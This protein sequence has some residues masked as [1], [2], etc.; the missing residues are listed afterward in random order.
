M[1]KVT[2]S[3]CVLIGVL[4]VCVFLLSS[5]I[6]FVE[7]VVIKDDVVFR[8]GDAL[9]EVSDNV[10]MHNKIIMSNDSFRLGNTYF[11]NTDWSSSD[12]ISFGYDEGY[13][14]NFSAANTSNVLK[15]YNSSGL[16]E[17]TG[18]FGVS[19]NNEFKGSYSSSLLMLN[20]SYWL[21]NSSDNN[22]SLNYIPKVSLNSPPS[23]VVINDSG[24]LLNY[25]V[26]VVGGA[27]VTFNVWSKNTD[28]LSDY[29]LRSSGVT[30]N[31]YSLSTG[32][33]EGDSVLVKVEA[34]DDFSCGGLSD[35]RVYDYENVSA[36]TTNNLFV[37][38][39]DVLYIKDDLVAGEYYVYAVFFELNSSDYNETEYEYVNISVDEKGVVVG[40]AESFVR[41]KSSESVKQSNIFN[42]FLY[43]E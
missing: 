30:I 2:I 33:R 24:I 35:S 16:D 29:A 22:G 6:F 42:N 12:R 41:S 5:P 37:S 7:A 10:S 1:E 23:G 19:L 17:R 9:F 27:P 4:V 32:F 18:A 39:N 21:V 3:N 36:N 40:R 14:F 34:C 8:F 26:S 13:S 31:S 28:S 20:G 43:N 11:L 25:S 38:D 15:W